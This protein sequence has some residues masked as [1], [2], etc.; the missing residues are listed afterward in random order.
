MGRF[1]FDAFDAWLRDSRKVKDEHRFAY[2]QGAERILQIAGDAPLRPA[3]VEEAIRR[4]IDAGATPKAVANLRTIGDAALAFARQR[5]I[6]PALAPA[7]VEAGGPERRSP[8]VIALPVVALLA[9]VGIG[10]ALYPRTRVAPPR[11]FATLTLRT[12]MK[13]RVDALSFE[14]SYSW[15]PGASGLGGP[16]VALVKIQTEKAR[17]DILHFLHGATTVSLAQKD[18]RE[19]RF[20]A[21]DAARPD[22]VTGLEIIDRNGQHY[23]FFPSNGRVLSGDGTKLWSSGTVDWWRTPEVTVQLAA[24]GCHVLA[25]GLSSVQQTVNTF[26]VRIEVH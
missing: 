8:L 19:I 3:H 21:T 1:D 4:E 20:Y 12:G 9:I 11:G 15:K 6:A 17:S 2:R 26:P 24:P 25:V 10:A 18:L 7:S 14:Y 13:C 5:P 16:A 22:D 23:D